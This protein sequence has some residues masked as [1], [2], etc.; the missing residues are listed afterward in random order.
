MSRRGRSSSPISL[1]SFQ[2]IITSVTAVIILIT[3]L[4]VV[5][6]VHRQLSAAE[7]TVADIQDELSDAVD[8]AEQQKAALAARLEQGAAV[9]Q[10][11]TTAPAE[12]QDAVELQRQLEAL[13]AEQD[14]LRQQLESAKKHEETAMASKFDRREE[15]AEL[16][17]LQ[18]EIAATEQAIQKQQQANVQHEQQVRDLKAQQGESANNNRRRIYNPAAGTSK[19]AWLVDVHTD[20]LEVAPLGKSAT[21]VSLAFSSASR[22]GPALRNWAKDLSSRSNYFILV[23]RPNGTEA[24]D[25]LRTSIE[26][27][28]YEVGFD[29]VGQDEVILDPTKGAAR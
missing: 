5:E 23:L 27:A 26:A 4:L 6:L 22:S 20:R 25:S 14:R 24:F 2:D 13:R 21:P 18:N 16:D 10:D 11:S 3:L 12:V 28:G 15:Q 19:Q 9:L 7:T 29:L 17:R 1:F 8:Q